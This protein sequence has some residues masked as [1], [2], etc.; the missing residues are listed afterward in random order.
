MVAGRSFKDRRPQAIKNH[1]TNHGTS[2]QYFKV[3]NMLT[4]KSWP[5]DQSTTLTWSWQTVD[6]KHNFCWPLCC[7]PRD[8]FLAAAIHLLAVTTSWR[9]R[10]ETHMHH[11]YCLSL[12][13]FHRTFSLNLNL[14][15][16]CWFCHIIFWL[17][18]S[19]TKQW[20]M[21]FYIFYHHCYSSCSALHII[22]SL[23]KLLWHAKLLGLHAG[24]WRKR[25]QPVATAM[26]GIYDWARPSEAWLVHDGKCI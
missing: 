24:H 12:L 5:V 4:V 10:Q 23:W 25:L 22:R 18:I 2:Q 8:M 11:D 6:V 20:P 9:C 21:I 14:N 17:A 16:Q 15:C 3:W 1:Q 19:P 26:D 7:P 13:T